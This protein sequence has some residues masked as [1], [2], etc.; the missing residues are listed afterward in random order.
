MTSSP[1]DPT[2][3]RHAPA[4]ELGH[5]VRLLGDLLGETLAEQRGPA[6]LALIED[7]R[8]AAIALR[9]GALPRGRDAFAEKVAGLDLDARL[10]GG[11]HFFLYDSVKIF[12][13]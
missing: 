5:D 7:V 4:E 2:P 9:Q 8:Q 6:A 11:I 13:L 10:G 3:P 12:L 1:V